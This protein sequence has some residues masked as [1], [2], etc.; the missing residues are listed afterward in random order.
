MIAAGE[1]D[2]AAQYAALYNRTI[3]YCFYGT[4]PAP[5]RD[6]KPY[7]HDHR[8]VTGRSPG[9]EWHTYLIKSG[10]CVARPTTNRDAAI[11]A[12]QNELEANADKLESIIQ[13]A[14]VLKND[15]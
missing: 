7:P 12:A 13:N 9:G 15:Y 6:A 8:F 1:Y 3:Y 2:N 5:I 11:L 14:K 4:G 10:Q